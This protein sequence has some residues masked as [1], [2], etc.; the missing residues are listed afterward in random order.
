MDDLVK[1]ITAL[2]P[3][4]NN[5]RR[6]NF[7]TFLTNPYMY[8]FTFVGAQDG[9]TPSTTRP[10]DLKGAPLTGPLA[11]LHTSSAVRSECVDPML[12]RVT[13][14]EEDVVNNWRTTVYILTCTVPASSADAGDN[15][16]LRAEAFISRNHMWKLKKVKETLKG[17]ANSVESAKIAA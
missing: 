1:E 7:C 6:H 8:P 16:V 10:R 2:R 13:R 5:G 3:T 17:V 9:T 11:L 12:A 15:D 4:A 14:H